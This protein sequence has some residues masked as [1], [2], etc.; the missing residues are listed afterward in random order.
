MKE[1]VRWLKE[2][3]RWLRRVPIT[4]HYWVAVAL[5]AICFGGIGVSGWSEKAFRLTGTLLQLCGVLTVVLGILKTR[6]DFRQEPVRS[7]FKRWT[8]MFPPLHPP[9][10]KI[11]MHGILPGITVEG[12]GYSTHG[13]ATDQSFEGRLG[14]LED[15]VKKLATAQG[16]TQ[17]AVHQAEKKAQKALDE[18]ARQLSGQINAVGKTIEVTATS[19]IHTSAM[20]VIWLFFGT[21]FGGAALELHKLLIP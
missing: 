8:K 17:I 3:G 9:T 6:A 16:K 5:V 21:V 13:P 2:I 4:R 12:H 10:V 18:Q 11:S 7:Q 1:F 19:G 15:V 20:G 14:H